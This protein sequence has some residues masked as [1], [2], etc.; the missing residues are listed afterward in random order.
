MSKQT[1]ITLTKFF[2]ALLCTV[3]QGCQGIASIDTN[4]DKENFDKYFAISKVEVYEQESDIKQA[5]QYI[6]LVE[7]ESC[8]VRANDVPAN[9]TEARTQA[10]KQAA[11]L[12]ANALV[13][14]SCINI[15]DTQCHALLV[16]Y[17]KAYKVK[18]ND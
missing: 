11:S 14:S 17:G 12:N 5:Y 3:L 10:R 9:I 16:C 6:D 15:E 13:I 18:F 4:L 2:F 7:G 8:Q 1:Y